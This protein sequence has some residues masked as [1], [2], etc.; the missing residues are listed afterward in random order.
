MKI[1][2]IATHA[3][4]LPSPAHT[5]DSQVILDL[6]R[7]L[8]E[9]GHDV[10]LLAPTGTKAHEGVQVLETPLIPGDGTDWE[11]RAGEQHFDALA[12]CDVLHDW[13][14]KKTIAKQCAK[15]EV[16]YVATL[17]G[18]TAYEPMPNTVVWSHAMRDRVM[19]GATDYENTATPD[20]GGPVCQP[21]KD[22]RVVYGGVDTEFYSPGRRGW[23][24]HMLWLN[25]WHPVKGYMQAIELAKKWGFRLVMAGEHPDND[26]P[27]QAKCAR[28]ALQLAQGRTNITFEW[29]PAGQDH[30]TVKRDLYR[31]ADG[32]IYPVQFQEPFGLSMVEAMACGAVVLGEM[33]G[34]VSE[35]TGG[36]N[37]LDAETVN[38]WLYEIYTNHSFRLRAVE[39]FDRFVMAR[40]YI[41]AYRD[42][43]DGKG[44]G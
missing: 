13:T 7:S 20:N 24:R 42:V 4:P 30:H 3:H 35:V 34:S 21:F 32:L 8:Y 41:A 40:N 27:Y 6:T 23:P 25:R 11:T 43:I 37:T 29:L 5:G 26:H 1:A 33:R 15:D 2:V 9:L 39:L 10:M 14:I 17:L 44:W 18:G 19:R 16:P 28:E 22:V 31:R 12:G 36:R 38:Y